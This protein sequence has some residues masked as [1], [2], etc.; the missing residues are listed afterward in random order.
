MS[1]FSR[2]NVPVIHQSET[3]ECG[4]ACLVMVANYHGLKVTLGWARQQLSTSARGLTLKTLIQQADFLSLNSRPVQAGLDLLSEINLPAIL[5]WNL[6]H[7]VVLEKVKGDKYCIIDPAIGKKILNKGEVSDKY[8]GILLELWPSTEF[9]ARKEGQKLRLGDL[10][11]DSRGVPEFITSTV[12]LSLFIQFTAIV[13]PLFLQFVADNV[14]PSSDE[15]LLI[16]LALGFGLLA[17][18]QSVTRVLRSFIFVKFGNTLYMQISDNVFKHLV[19]LPLTFF[20]RRNIADVVERFH[21]IAPLK[22]LLSEGVISALIDG[23]GALIIVVAMY[24]YSPLL[25]S[26]T[27]VGIGI[28]ILIKVL[29]F[30]PLRQLNEVAVV[31]GAAW[32]SVFME[33]IRGIVSIRLAGKETERMLQWKKEFSQNVGSEVKTAKL[34]ALSNS[35]IDL[36]FGIEL[37]VAVYLTAKLV[38]AGTFSLGMLF[39]YLSFRLQLLDRTRTFVDRFYEF[40]M[41]NLHLDRLSDIVLTAREPISTA[42]DYLESSGTFAIEMSDIE[43]SYSPNDPLVLKGC[44]LKIE[45]GEFVAIT[46]ESGCGKTTLIRTLLGVHE[47]NDGNIQ[48]FDKSLRKNGRSAFTG[49]MSSVMQDDGLF[50]ASLAQNISFFDENPDRR[51][52]VEAAKLAH[53]HAD[54]VAMPMGYETA[55]GEVGTTLSGGQQQRVL[56]ARAIYQNAPILILDEGTSHL[57]IVTEKKVLQNL[58]T[59]H[60]TR[61]LVA[62]RPETIS[63]ADKVFAMRNGQL[64]EV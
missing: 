23:I 62:H 14:I 24:I 26:V 48:V 36:V 53:I 34:T 29:T 59:L 25:A 42:S 50:M 37:I 3:T 28:Y 5:Y 15:Q 39:A 49:F 32:R 7:F 20:G 58:S 17:I 13:G 31:K 56:L 61:I 60:L 52:I 44:N 6:D 63:Y 51:R 1:Y 9:K 55:I 47:P 12:V 2:R 40:R 57:D 22:D 18:L 38:I 30:S 35:L 27:M 21:A 10:W 4:L 45:K 54:I 46:G 8:T 19:H 43:F 16:T 11:G 33:T 64:H 41:Y